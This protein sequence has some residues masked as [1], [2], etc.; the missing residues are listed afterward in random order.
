MWPATTKSTRDGSIHRVSRSPASRIRNHGAPPTASANQSPHRPPRPKVVK[1]KKPSALPAADATSSEAEASSTPK[2]STTHHAWDG[3]HPF[4]AATHGFTSDFL[5]RHLNLDGHLLVQ[6]SSAT[7]QT[8]AGPNATLP[9]AVRCEL[10]LLDAS[11]APVPGQHSTL[12]KTAAPVVRTSH[13]V[14]ADTASEWSLSHAWLEPGSEP[15]T[16]AASWK[17]AGAEQ[18]PEELHVRVPRG[19]T[20]SLRVR[21]VAQ[22]GVGLLGGRI[23]MKALKAQLHGGWHDVPLRAIAADD[24]ARG[25]LAVRVLFLDLPELYTMAMRAR[26]AARVALSEGDAYGEAMGK[27]ILGQAG[28]DPSLARTMPAPRTAAAE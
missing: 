3:A 10:E 24:D 27:F 21:I 4:V 15:R 14:N 28:R 26:G 23:E 18:Q 22:G 9:A 6:L 8:A 17:G 7:I 1:K 16:Y 19:S 2:P 11:G 25:A 5:W 13:L 12:S 20:G